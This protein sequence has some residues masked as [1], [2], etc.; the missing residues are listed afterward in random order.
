[1][2]SRMIKAY[3]IVLGTM[4]LL[5]TG[6]G[7]EKPDDDFELPE[8]A[9]F[10]ALEW[11]EA[12]ESMHE[13]ISLEY[14]FTELRDVD[15]DQK[16]EEYRPLIEKAWEENDKRAYYT[17]L[18]SYLFSI[19]DGHVALITGRSYNDDDMGTLWQ[20][21]G[22]GFGMTVAF[23]DDRRLVADWVEEIGP[24]GRAGM[25][26]GAEIIEWDGKTA[27]VALRET[28]TIWSVLPQATNVGRD[29]ERT[30]FMVRAPEGETRTVTFQ[31]PDSAPTSAS[32][33]AVDDEME[34]LRMTDVFGSGFS[35]IPVDKFIEG[36]QLEDG[37]GYIKLYGEADK[38][39]QVPTIDQF[40]EMIEDFEAANARGLIIDLRGNMGGADAMAAAFLGS[41]YSTKTLYEY[42]S[43]YN[44]TTGE[45]E[46]VLFD[47]TTGEV[48]R[49]AG[50]YIEPAPVSFTG[51]VV[52]LVN[53]GCISS[54]EGIAMG[55]RNLDHGEVVGFRGTNGSFG[56]VMGPVI[57]MPGGYSI[58]YPVGQSLDRDRKIQLDSNEREGGVAPTIRVP[59]TME[60]VLRSASG[61]DVELEYALEVLKGKQEDA[62]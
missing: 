9:D 56:M 24:A 50:L 13:K 35:G 23:L 26:A 36:R 43:W 19:P 60:N 22:G 12:F 33:T 27:D 30:R 52:A 20:E 62:P 38:P 40:T 31:N 61:I 48:R 17:L 8:V 57:E 5:S 14:A 4:I 39:D 15:W 58:M 2:E 29:Y 55:I 49:D 16:I 42:T 11:V 53:P 46:I 25:E 32:L 45:M 37:I 18:R 41:F 47:E 54:G 3:A 44:L 7:G 51:R 34:T 6:C 10:S 21:V 59:L 28:S 1:M